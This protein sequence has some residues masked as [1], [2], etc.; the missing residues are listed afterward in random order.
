MTN[1][2]SVTFY[3]AMK[4]FNGRRFIQAPSKGKKLGLPGD[5]N[6]GGDNTPWELLINREKT[7]EISSNSSNPIFGLR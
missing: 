4:T 3:L 1:G 7:R 6:T 2:D 5:M